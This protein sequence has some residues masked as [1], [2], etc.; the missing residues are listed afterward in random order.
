MAAQ[1][2]PGLHCIAGCSSSEIQKEETGAVACAADVFYGVNQVPLIF[3]N[4]SNAASHFGE[5]ACF[6]A[7][8]SLLSE[9]SGRQMVKS[10]SSGSD[11][12]SEPWDR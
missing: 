5:V 12:L 4:V 1:G 11:V 9:M 2:M 3:L 8:S 7:R 10:C 6:W